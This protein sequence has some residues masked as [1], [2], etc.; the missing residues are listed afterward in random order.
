MVYCLHYLHCS[1]SPRTWSGVFFC[2][3]LFLANI[4]SLCSINSMTRPYY[5]YIMTNFSK[6]VLYI[7]VTNNLMRRV[8]EHKQGLTEGFSKK[9]HTKY[10][11]YYEETKN[12][13]D[14]IRREKQLKKWRKSR[15]ESLISTC[16]P[17]RNDI[18]RCR[19]K[20]GMT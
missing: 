9:Y 5:V 18:S 1:L 17:T 2:L 8:F 12:I 7:G 13:M 14:A 16:N 6:T 15:K 11:L 20:S 10:L 4:V 3:I 19:I